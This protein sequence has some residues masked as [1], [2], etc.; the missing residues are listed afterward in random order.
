MLLITAVAK[1]SSTGVVVFDAASPDS[2][3]QPGYES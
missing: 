1:L 3:P 2:T